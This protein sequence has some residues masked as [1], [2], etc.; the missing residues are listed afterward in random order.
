[1]NHSLCSVNHR[2]LPGKLCGARVAVQHVGP[3]RRWAWVA[4]LP[5]DG[6]WEPRTSPQ[7]EAAAPR[8]L[9]VHGSGGGK[10]L[11]E[12][13]PVWQ[14]LCLWGGLPRGP[15]R[16]LCSEEVATVDGPPCG[17]WR[18]WRA[19]LISE[20]LALGAWRGRREEEAVQVESWKRP[21]L[22]Q[23]VCW[24]RCWF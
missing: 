23:S 3:V 2:A 22:K 14:P 5:V 9:W 13:L 24:R 16:E 21:S 17:R 18:S 8:E 1:M 6:N 15:R 7:A 19:A 20:G 4:G 12:Q 11:W 10:A